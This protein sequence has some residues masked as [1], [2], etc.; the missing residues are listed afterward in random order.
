MGQDKI[1]R[2]IFGEDQDSF[3]G[4]AVLLTTPRIAFFAFPA[5]HLI[6][7]E[8]R[9]MAIYIRRQKIANIWLFWILPI[10]FQQLSSIDRMWGWNSTD[11]NFTRPA[12]ACNFFCQHRKWSLAAYYDRLGQIMNVGKMQL[13]LS[14]KK[15]LFPTFIITPPFITAGGL[16]SLGRRYIWPQCIT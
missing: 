4:A 11:S 14:R 5:S 3:L 9:Y 15:P 7:S 2:M 6:F 10:I 8:I 1:R 16:S 13:H 12:M